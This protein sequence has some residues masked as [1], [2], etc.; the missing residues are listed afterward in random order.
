MP[1]M[2]QFDEIRRGRQQRDEVL[3]GVARPEHE[4]DAE[5][6]NQLRRAYEHSHAQL[7]GGEE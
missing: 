6:Q 5:Q 7:L 2:P 1:D 4:G 3:P